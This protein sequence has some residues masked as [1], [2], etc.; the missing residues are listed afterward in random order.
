M[1]LEKQLINK[2]YYKTFTEGSENEHPIKVLGEL[3][4]LEQQKEVTDLSYI[5]FAQGEVYFQNKD[6]ETAIFKWE[7]IH[8]ELMPWAQKN[9]ADANFELGFYEIAEEYYKLVETDSDDL[10]VEVLLQLFSLYIQRDKLEMAAKSI[11]NAVE[12]SPDYPHVTDMARSF[13]EEQQDYASGVELAVAEAIRTE[14]LFWFE[15]LEAYVKDGHT[16]ATAP[17]YFRELLMTLYMVNQTRF[18]SI[19]AALWDSYKQNDLYFQWLKEINYLLSDINPRRSNWQELSNHYKE[20]YLQLMNGT[21]LI[22][23]LSDYIPFHLTNWIKIATG[24]DTLAASSAV[25]AWNELFPLLMND[26]VVSEAE[27]LMSQSNHNNNKRMGDIFLIFESIRKWANGMGLSMGE[28]TEAIID[29]L[30]DSNNFHLLI[31]GN[32]PTRKAS[33][34][35]GLLGKEMAAASNTATV[36][37]KHDDQ[38]DINVITDQEEK[39]NLSWMSSCKLQ[40]MNRHTFAVKCQYRFWIKINLL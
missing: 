12:L 38:E 30:L 15:V 8:N 11:K 17:A 25:L 18:E 28:H 6:Y 20:T 37:F 39:E 31:T 1:T 5:R 33:I 26:S 32:E 34:V 4:I 10:K 24:S 3:S 21:Y 7:N 9:I 19:V 13:F 23:D 27:G 14:S 22:K 40:R 16:A 2:C 29:E 36:L 35:N